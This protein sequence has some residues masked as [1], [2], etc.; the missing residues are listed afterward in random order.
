MRAL[1]V[2]LTLAILDDLLAKPIGPAAA[3]ETAA[4]QQMGVGIWRVLGAG[5][6]AFWR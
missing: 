2:D 5:R 1:E 4:A 6:C 3:V